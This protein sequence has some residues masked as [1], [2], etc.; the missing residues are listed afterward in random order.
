[1]SQEGANGVGVKFTGVALVMKDN[2]SPNPTTVRIFSPEAQMPEA[3]NVTDLVEE[4]SFGH[5]C[6]I[7]HMGVLWCSCD[8]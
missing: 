2:E 5:C 3:R 6:I 8:I 1:M 7:P 4:F